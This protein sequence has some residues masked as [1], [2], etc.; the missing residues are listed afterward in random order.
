LANVILSA[1]DC[2]W[3][4]KVPSPPPGVLPVIADGLPVIQKSV[5]AGAVIWLLVTAITGF[6]VKLTF[7]R[8]KELQPVELSPST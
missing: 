3:Y 8:D 7:P 5:T 1:D 6:T 2:H 4:E